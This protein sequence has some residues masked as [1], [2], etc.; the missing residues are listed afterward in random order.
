MTH[1]QVQDVYRD[2]MLNTIDE[3]HGHIWLPELQS[4]L[5]NLPLWKRVLKR[6][7]L[8]KA[9]PAAEWEQIE[10]QMNKEAEAHD[11]AKQMVDA[12]PRLDYFEALRV[13]RERTGK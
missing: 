12:N 3:D 6:I 11:Q 5:P 7:G 2:D 10:Q 4:A 8:L 1:N 9:N 13:A